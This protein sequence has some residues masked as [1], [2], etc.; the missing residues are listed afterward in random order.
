ARTFLIFRASHFRRLIGLAET[1][2]PREVIDETVM[3][4]TTSFTM[5]FDEES[6]ASIL[7]W[8]VYPSLFPARNANEHVLEAKRA[9]DDSAKNYAMREKYKLAAADPKAPDKEK[10]L[11][12]G[13]AQYQGNILADALEKEAL[14]LLNGAWDL[15][16]SQDAK[17]MV[18][19]SSDARAK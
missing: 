19:W 10:F 1:M 5:G 4:V 15:E 2:E 6:A 18:M 11:F 16:G 3:A 17:A 9:R 12:W 7:P 14:R 8:K 13:E